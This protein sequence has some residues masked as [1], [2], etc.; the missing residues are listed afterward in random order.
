MLESFARHMRKM[1]YAR[2]R[3]MRGLVE[4]EVRDAERLTIESGRASVD[5]DHCTRC[6]ACLRIGHC[7]A[8]SE[9]GDGEPQLQTEKCT[10]CGTCADVCPAGAITLTRGA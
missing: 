4:R 1:G 3:E 9:A 2:P 5:G 8:I 7:G 10:A 6:G